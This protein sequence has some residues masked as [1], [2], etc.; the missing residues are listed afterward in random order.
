M[1]LTKIKIE[2]LANEIKDFLI[3]NELE[4]DT[5]IY[6]NDKKLSFKTYDENW[7]RLEK[8][9]LVIKENVCPL[10]Y[11]KYA[12]ARH[13]LSMSFEGSLYHAINFEYNGVY[14]FFQ[15]IFDK[16]GLYFE[17]G[18]A[19][20]LTAYPNPGLEYSD[21]E[22]T[23]YED[24]KEKEPIYIGMSRKENA[25]EELISIMDT[26]YQLSDKYGDEGSCVIG[27]GFEFEYDSEKYFMSAC[28]PYQGSCSWESGIDT[29][30]GMLNELGAKDINY[31]WGVMD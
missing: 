28:S 5:S 26:W 8:S 29:V 21:I 31:N 6:F 17:Q 3:E 18:N 16:Y 4:S 25:P 27:A 15:N 10:D 11:F 19:W 1:K 13:I 20:N 23:D 7:K 9:E 14:D 24:K 12:N 22:Y 2:E 30:R